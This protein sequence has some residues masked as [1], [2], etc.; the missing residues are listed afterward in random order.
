MNILGIIKGVGKLLGTTV[1]G[2]TGV[3]SA[4][5]KSVFDTAGVDV[6]SEVFGAVKD[7]SFNGIRNMWDI[8]APEAEEYVSEEDARI[9]GI[10]EEIRKLKAQALKCKGLASKAA[11]EH[12]REN[13][14]NRYQSLMEE[15]DYLQAHMYD[16]D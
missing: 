9:A 2:A 8:E 13:F 3:A 14:M 7:A 1:L 4:V 10:K 6:G 15:A 16:N 12:I 11:D 5:L